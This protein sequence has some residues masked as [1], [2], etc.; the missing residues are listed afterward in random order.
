MSLKVSEI[1]F[2]LQGE[3]P[4]VGYP[5][6]FIRLFGCNLRCTWCDTTYAREG[7]N[8]RVLS[9]QEIL[10]LWEKNYSSI[11]FITLTGGE[12]LLQGKIYKLMKEFIKR[13]CTVLVETNGSLDIKNVPREVIKVVDIKTPSSGMDKHNLY[14]NLKYLDLKDAVKFVIK[15]KMDF[16]FALD[17]I[18]TWNLLA[19]TQVFFSPVYAELSPVTLAQW[20]LELRLPIR[21]QLQLHK[22]L[23]LK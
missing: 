13:N 15:D 11:P 1:F 2:S 17:I 9:V 16:Q 10:G 19:K 8:Y 6:F 7:D 14:T 21:F 5:T 22:I 23:N 4:L 12:P 20:I 3:G 18:Q